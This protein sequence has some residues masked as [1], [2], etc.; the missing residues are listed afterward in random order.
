MPETADVGDEVRRLVADRLKLETDLRN[1]RGELPDRRLRS[2]ERAYNGLQ[3]SLAQLFKQAGDDSQRITIMLELI[4]ILENKLVYLQN[5]IIDSTADNRVLA[6]LVT[7]FLDQLARG[8]SSV[9]TSLEVT[10]YRG[11]VALYAGALPSARE[12]FKMACE[13][14]ESDEANDI[15]YK[16]YVILG[17]L[18][19][20]AADYAEA[21]DLHDRSLQYSQHNNVTAQ[22]LAFKALNAYALREFDEALEL[23]EKALALFEQNEPFFNS[24]FFR[25]SLL[26]CGSI[27]FERKDYGKAESAYKRVVEQVEPLSYDYFDALAQLGRIY[28]STSRFEDAAGAF[29]R[30]IEHHRFSENEYLVDTYFWL[31]KTHL[32][33]NQPGEAK[34]YLE[35]VA[36]S[37]IQSDKRSQARELL[38]KVS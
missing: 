23:F 7:Q 21:R 8:T 19:H 20:E 35:K 16:S 38:A 13:S 31:A 5:F 24:Y 33:R 1:E 12:H 27:H 32:R 15:K 9:L 29:S 14:E 22:A 28:Y 11:I 10:Y 18:S 34:Q 2:Y 25:N 37:E 17:H 30:A 6:S 4:R 3:R 26:F 36:G